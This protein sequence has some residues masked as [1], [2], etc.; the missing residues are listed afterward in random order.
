MGNLDIVYIL[1]ITFFYTDFLY[2]YFYRK[3]LQCKYSL[4][5]TILITIGMWIFDCTV[6][7]IPQYIFEID[8]SVFLN[9][10]MTLSSI[11]YVLMVFQ[12]TIIKR[13]MATLVYMIVQMLM[14]IAGM[15]LAVVFTGAKEIF[16]IKYLNVAAF[17]SCLMIT[18]GT[19]ACV[20]IWKKIEDRKWRIDNYQWFCMI[21]PISQYIIFQGIAARQIRSFEYVNTVVALGGVIAFLADII[22]LWMFEKS[23][24]R[25]KA[26]IEMRHL[27]QQYELE[28]M[29]YEQLK[30]SQEEMAKMRHDFQ[31][32]VLVLKHME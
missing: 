32:Y 21:L 27:N 31:N 12:G 17:C 10:I 13:L 22:M 2:F 3:I 26:E 19:V 16:D 1:A 4:K 25:R 7:L 28:K 15:E 6:K 24:A 9:V 14:D 30:E 5:T 11:V 20:W 18:L 8:Q 23:N 29:R